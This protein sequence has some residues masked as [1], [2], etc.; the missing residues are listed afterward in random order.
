MKIYT[1]TGDQGQTSLYGGKRV[2]KHSLRID[3]YGTLDELNSYIGLIRDLTH[4]SNQDELLSQIQHTLFD[5]GSHLAADPD[6]TQLKKPA[7]EEVLIRQ[8]EQAI[9]LMNEEIPPLKLFILP[10]GHPT[11][12]HIHIA[13]TLCRK[14]ERRITELAFNEEIN[15]IIIP[16]INRLSDYLFVF[17]R[18][19]AKQNNVKEYFWNPKNKS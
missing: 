17:A 18:Y 16:Y 8:L 15:L 1:K 19:I 6:K 14:S 9:D 10:G 4:G 5:I 12:S 3:S 7:L 11:V 13:R 2:Q